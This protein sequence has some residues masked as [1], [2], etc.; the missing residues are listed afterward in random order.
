MAAATAALRYRV[1]AKR[2]AAYCVR[3]SFA[4]PLRSMVCVA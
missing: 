4:V 2:L 3:G 1:A